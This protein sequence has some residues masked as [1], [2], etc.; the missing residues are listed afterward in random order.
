MKAVLDVTLEIDMDEAAQA[1]RNMRSIL[2]DQYEAVGRKRSW[3]ASE[4]AMVRASINTKIAAI[5]KFLALGGYNRM[6]MT[7]K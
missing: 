6:G 4:T 5:N 7:S 3:R 2:I 1:L